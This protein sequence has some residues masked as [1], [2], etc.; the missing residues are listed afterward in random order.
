MCPHNRGH[1]TDCK[2][3]CRTAPTPA[4][5][6]AFHAAFCNSTPSNSLAMDIAGTPGRGGRLKYTSSWRAGPGTW[7]SHGTSTYDDSQQTTGGF[8]TIYPFGRK[9]PSLEGGDISPFSGSC[10][11]LLDIVL[12]NVDR[13][14]A[15]TSGEVRRRPERL[16]AGEDVKR[17]QLNS[18]MALKPRK[19]RRRWIFPGPS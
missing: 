2:P 16:Q 13:P 9:A 5:C 12:Q 10:F 1:C 18:A 15:A 6:A 19:L 4:S 17:I 7:K 8:V 3:P 11:L 14:T